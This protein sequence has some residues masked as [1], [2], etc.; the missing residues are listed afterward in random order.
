MLQIKD[1]KGKKFKFPAIY[2]IRNIVTNKYYVGQAQ[3]LGKRFNDYR[4]G[5]FNEKMENT[6]NKHGIKNF[7]VEI[8]AK[9]M[10]PIDD[11][12]V[13]LMA[14]EYFYYNVVGAWFGV[15]T[16][17]FATMIPFLLLLGLLQLIYFKGLRYPF[18]C[19]ILL[20]Y[21]EPLQGLSQAIFY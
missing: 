20:I 8:L 2:G 15:D 6:I 4:R 14:L 21:V 11:D 3:N 1:V 16:P 12:D 9:D 5:D 10:E 19:Y 7:E 18:L 13:Y 17:M